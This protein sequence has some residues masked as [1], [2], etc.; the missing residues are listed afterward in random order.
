MIVVFIHNIYQLIL[1]S[2]FSIFNHHLVGKL[3]LYEL[4][5]KF[6][7]IRVVYQKIF[8]LPHDFTYVFV[9]LAFAI[10]STLASQFD[11]ANINYSKCQSN[12][13]L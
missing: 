7:E 12:A 2:T 6:K 13:I 3:V 5:V 1:N 4:P 9:H 8:N 10:I 11:E